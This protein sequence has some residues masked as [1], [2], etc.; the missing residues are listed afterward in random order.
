MIAQQL[1]ES[2]TV[3]F[4]RSSVNMGVYGQRHCFVY[5]SFLCLS[6]LASA[7]IEFFVFQ[8]SFECLSFPTMRDEH[9]SHAIAIPN[10]HSSDDGDLCMQGLYLG[11]QS[12]YGRLW[13]LCVRRDRGG[14]RLGGGIVD[15]RRPLL[16]VASVW[17]PV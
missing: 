7:R 11:G 3:E 16:V 9:M 17:A 2:A 12:L 8:P 14:R 10:A 5:C 1:P 6:S 13:A 4:M 15:E